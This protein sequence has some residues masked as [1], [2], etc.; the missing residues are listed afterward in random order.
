MDRTATRALRDLESV[1]QALRALGEL[2]QALDHILRETHNQIRRIE[3]QAK[4]RCAPLRRRARALER[5]LERFCACHPELLGPGQR[6]DLPAGS[7]GFTIRRTL[8]PAPGLSWAGIAPHLASTALPPCPTSPAGIDP[9]ALAALPEATLHTLG[10]TP[11]PHTTFW[12][13]P[14]AGRGE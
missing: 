12:C 7:L 6:L 13:K 2:R 10:I 4:R 14:K 3:A 8:R 5:R 1:S 11:T 9:H